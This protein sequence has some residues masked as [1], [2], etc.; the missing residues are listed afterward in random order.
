[1]SEQQKAIR[2]QERG[3]RV[4]ERG[5]Q[6]PTFGPRVSSVQ[7][8]RSLGLLLSSIC[9]PEP[10]VEPINKGARHTYSRSHMYTRLPIASYN[11]K[12]SLT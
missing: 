7:V 4:T 3:K 12:H 5:R 11:L 2:K 10:V 6:G 1:M 9:L 8:C